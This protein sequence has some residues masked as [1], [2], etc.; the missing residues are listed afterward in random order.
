MR[1]SAMN[2]PTVLLGGRNEGWGGGGFAVPSGTSG[3]GACGCGS[4]H[5]CVPV[6]R[7]V[8]TPEM[9]MRTE[10]LK[11][12]ETK[13]DAFNTKTH[14]D[15]APSNKNCPSSNSH[16]VVWCGTYVQFFLGVQTK[17]SWRSPL[18]SQYSR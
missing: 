17:M 11:Q 5:P 15:Q 7:G 6:W 2:R 18:A 4:V 10:T 3:K 14:G 1:H 12:T 9:L 8:P 13:R 16:G